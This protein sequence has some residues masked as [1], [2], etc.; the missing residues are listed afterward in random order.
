MTKQDVINSLIGFAAKIF[1]TD[2]AALSADTV[3]SELGTKSLQRIGMCALIEND[4]D[5]VL[6]IADFGQYRTIG[7]LAD[8]VLDEISKQ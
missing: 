2:A 6:P 7:D 1:K 3:I 5:V 4:L 8:R